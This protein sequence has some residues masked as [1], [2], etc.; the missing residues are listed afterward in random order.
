MPAPPQRLGTRSPRLSHFLHLFLSLSLLLS[1]SLQASAQ[2]PPSHLQTPLTPPPTDLS[3]ELK[4]VMMDRASIQAPAHWRVGN[5]GSTDIQSMHALT[6]TLRSPDDRMFLHILLIDPF[7]LDPGWNISDVLGPTLADILVQSGARDSELKDFFD[8]PCEVSDQTTKGRLVN[9]QFER[10]TADPLV[11]EQRLLSGVACG[12]SQR[13]RWA[14]F[15]L[16]LDADN[17]RPA[18]MRQLLQEARDMMKSF[19]FD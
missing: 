6:L 4:P 7:G 10:S 12:I 3:T 19:K 11:K 5:L 15:F 13:D 8:F 14:A 16:V 9:I 1:L 17:T 18:L 2:S